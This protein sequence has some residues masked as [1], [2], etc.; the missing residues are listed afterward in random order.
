MTRNES[1]TDELQKCSIKD[2]LDETAIKLT[3]N[4]AN[5]P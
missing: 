1:I 5:H 4:K 2:K 3:Q